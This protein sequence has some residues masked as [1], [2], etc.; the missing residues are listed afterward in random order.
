LSILE[1][2]LYSNGGVKSTG[3]FSLTSAISE[4]KNIVQLNLDLTSLKL[5]V[6]D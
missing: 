4:L 5:G 3:I 2:A 1:I 6:T